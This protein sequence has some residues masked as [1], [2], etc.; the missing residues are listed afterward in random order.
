MHDPISA[1]LVT[2]RVHSLAASALPSAP[3][4]PVAESRRRR[5]LARLRPRPA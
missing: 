2:D 4:V 5:V 3:V 1:L